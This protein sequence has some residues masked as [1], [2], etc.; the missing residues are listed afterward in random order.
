M[1]G[2]R[3]FA[4]LLLLLGLGHTQAATLSLDLGTGPVQ[5]DSAA[6]LADPATRTIESPN[7]VAY[8]LPMRYRALPLAE[9]LKGVATDAH[10]QFVASD[11]F[12][13]ELAA[14]PLLAERG[15]R[16]WLAVEDPAAPW[17]PLGAGK[18][19]SAGPF[20]L[21]WTDPAAGGIVPEQWPYQIA[22]IRRV[23]ELGARY[24]A[25]LPEARLPHSDPAWRGYAQ[26]TRHCL[27]CHTLNR[28]GGSQLGPDLNQPHN[29][30][31]YFGEAT[32]RAYIRDPQS[33]RY[34]PQARMPAFDAQVLPEADL[35]ALLAYLRQMQRQRGSP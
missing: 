17:P 22:A 26:F 23:D 4:C 28:Q 2:F 16:A 25:L 6:L 32:L 31:E 15:A 1:H 11:G 34:W 8:R 7:D 33:L 18:S 3:L 14:A 27:T 20:Y 21:V 10:L 35:D 29:P 12:V 5:R 24:P 9:L 30:L 13:A 19:G